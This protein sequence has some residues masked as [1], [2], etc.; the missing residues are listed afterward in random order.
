MRS[1][2]CLRSSVELMIRIRIRLGPMDARVRGPPI[3]DHVEPPSCFNVD[4]NQRALQPGGLALVV[5]VVVLVDVLVRALVVV[6]LV[7]VL[8][9]A[10]V[11]SV[12]SLIIVI[13]VEVLGRGIVPCPPLRR[14]WEGRE[15]SS[16]SIIGAEDPLL[17]RACRGIDVWDGRRPPMPELVRGVRGVRVPPAPPLD[18]PRVD[19]VR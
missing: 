16:P 14:L 12:P 7:D 6:V 19:R 9:R 3:E 15:P 17:V 10:F 18:G 4:F 1:S 5:F 13:T 11:P 2:L 8:V